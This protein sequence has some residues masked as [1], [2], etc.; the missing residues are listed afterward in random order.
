MGMQGHTLSSLDQPLSHV[1]SGDQAKPLGHIQVVDLL[2][3]KIMEHYESMWGTESDEATIRNIDARVLTHNMSW[4]HEPVLYRR[5][6]SLV[7]LPPAANYA[8]GGVH[9]HGVGYRPTRRSSNLLHR[10]YFPDSVCS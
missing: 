6:V 10:Q 7:H 9:L 5:L 4:L 8:R 2:G 3:P 1:A